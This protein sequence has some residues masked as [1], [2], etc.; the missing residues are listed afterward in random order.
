MAGTD[1]RL[2]WCRQYQCKVRVPTLV[3]PPEDVGR[4]T[5]PGCSISLTIAAGGKMTV[6]KSKTVLDVPIRGSYAKNVFH[7]IPCVLINSAS[8]FTVKQYPFS[9]MIVTR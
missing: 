4:V 1:V 9:L 8:P 2:R 5:D 6:H 7:F 3:P